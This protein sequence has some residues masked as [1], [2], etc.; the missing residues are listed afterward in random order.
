MK[1]NIRTKW[2][3]T[4]EGP[5]NNGRLKVCNFEFIFEAGVTPHCPQCGSHM[6]VVSN[7]PSITELLR[8]GMLEERENK[9]TG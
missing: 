1:S 6:K 4:S 8:R 5:V 7:G 3:C 2:R 9:K